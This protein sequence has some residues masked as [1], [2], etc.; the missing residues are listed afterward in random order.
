MNDETNHDDVTLRRLIRS[1]AGGFIEVLRGNKIATVLAAT[2][3]VVTSIFAVTSQYDERPRY[4]QVILPEIATS[5]AQLDGLLK[6]AEETE[7]DNWR[8]YYFIDAHQKARDILQLTRRR[9]P[10]TREG[11]RAHGELVRY[12]E[13]L[14]EDF[15]IIRTQMSLNPAMDYMA[16]WRKV[17]AERWPVREAWAGWVNG[18]NPGR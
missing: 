13:L 7:N 15:A 6:A 11:I 18:P 12:Y 9:W 4:R 5:E 14:T 10:H 8:I 16:A 2:A 1:I 3:L 17:R